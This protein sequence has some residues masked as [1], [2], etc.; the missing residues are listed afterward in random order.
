V[1]RGDAPGTFVV[2][3]LIESLV[4]KMHH[5]PIQISLLLLDPDLT[6]PGALPLAPFMPA[7]VTAC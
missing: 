7:I 2:V 1:I 5:E 3:I 4:L 6:V